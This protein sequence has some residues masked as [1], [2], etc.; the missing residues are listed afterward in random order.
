MHRRPNFSR[1]GQRRQR[2][3]RQV[4]TQGDGGRRR[5]QQAGFTAR[6]GC[7][8]SRTANSARAPFAPTRTIERLHHQQHRRVSRTGTGFR[9]QDARPALPPS[10]VSVNAAMV[11]L[12]SFSRQTSRRPPA[13]APT[14]GSRRISRRRSRSYI[15]AE[16]GVAVLVHEACPGGGRGY[17][18][19]ELYRPPCRGRCSGAPA[20]NSTFAASRSKRAIMPPSK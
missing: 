7:C 6:T 9:N 5:D 10:S 19:G 4:R 20:G 1:S 8:G 18:G 13:N 14:W 16:K 2:Q 11:G 12:T 17:Q 15:A 3:P